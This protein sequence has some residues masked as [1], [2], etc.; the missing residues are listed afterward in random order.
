ML[1]CS[2]FAGLLLFG[3]VAVAQD[4]DRSES[5]RTPSPDGQWIASVQEEVCAGARGAA[6]GI[7]VVV[8]SA[9]DESRAQRVFITAVPRSRDDWAR[10]RWEGNSLLQ[11]RVPN[12]AEIA[13][14][15]KPEFAGIRIELQYCGDNPDDRAKVAQYK[16]DVKQWQRDVT[17]WVQRRKQDPDAAGP[18]PPRPEEPRLPPGR[19]AD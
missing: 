15:P 5:R 10:V 7:T 14:A 11:I 16:L 1:D 2:R 4:C 6:A 13:E 9:T 17:A 12:L 8:S 3:T 18:R 19:C